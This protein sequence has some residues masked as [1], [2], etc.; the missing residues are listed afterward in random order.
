[1]L[2]LLVCSYIAISVAKASRYFQ[3][4]PPNSNFQ[5]ITPFEWASCGEQVILVLT[6]ELKTLIGHRKE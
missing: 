1:M 4:Y 5:S 2:F 3:P 6:T